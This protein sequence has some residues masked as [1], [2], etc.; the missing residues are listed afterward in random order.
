MF[1]RITLSAGLPYKA[2]LV[3]KDA[4]VLASS[5]V[6]HIQAMRVGDCA[7]SM[8]YHVEVEPDTVDNWGAVPAY[9]IALE[10][11]LGKGSLEGMRRK[12]SKMMQDFNTNSRKLFK[13]FCSASG[14]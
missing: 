9:K 13:N 11:S 10:E 14:F 4:V 3:P 1:A 6:C 7:W 5:S 12:S 2:I 8:Q